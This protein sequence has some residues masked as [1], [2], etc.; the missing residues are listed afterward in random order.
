MS[1]R[2]SSSIRPLLA[3][4]RSALTMSFFG[5]SFLT[6]KPERSRRLASRDWSRRGSRWHIGGQHGTGRG[7]ESEGIQGD[8]GSESSRMARLP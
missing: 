2:R 4:V 8:A 7:D 3:G 5:Q 6:T 1:G